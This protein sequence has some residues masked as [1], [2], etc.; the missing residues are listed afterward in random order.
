VIALANEGKTN[1]IL[2]FRSGMYERPQ[3]FGK[4]EVSAAQQ[5]TIEECQR[6]GRILKSAKKKIGIKTKI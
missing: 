5:T 3:N 4:T 2:L 1:K 6:A